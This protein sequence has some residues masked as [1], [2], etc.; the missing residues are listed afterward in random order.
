[1]IRATKDVTWTGGISELKK[2][3]TMAETPSTAMS[4]ARTTKV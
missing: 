4:R 1:V 3:A 2:M